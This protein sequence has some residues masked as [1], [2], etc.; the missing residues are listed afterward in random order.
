ME[1]RFS[2]I[3]QEILDAR[4][5]AAELS[6]LEVLTTSENNILTP[7]SN[8]KVAVWRVWVW[9][10]AFAIW[11]HE[12]IVNQNALNSRPHNVPWYREQV[13]AFLDGLQLVWINGQHSYDLT[14][15]NDVEARK[16]IKRT[17]V[18]E[19]NDGELV[20]KIATESGG[21]L[22]PLSAPQ[23][24][25][26]TE[27]MNL[28]KDAGNRLRI[29]NQSADLLKLTITAYVDVAIIDLETGR[30]LNV[31][32]DVYPVKDAVNEYLA[33]LD[34][35]GAFYRTFLQSTIEKATGVKLPLVTELQWKFADL[36]FQPFTEIKIPQ[37][38][39]FKIDELDLTIIYIDKNELANG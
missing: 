27:Y 30:L 34:F 9:V 21:E 18:L 31:D 13:F 11:I 8:S 39:Y 6:A 7:D 19:S 22:V 24:V 16:I 3:Q 33:N 25:R 29:I 37:A 32:G 4:N 23:L 36:D 1:R 38:G 12:K 20:I 17:A 35:N 14:N 2:E 5:D 10:I 26:F 15:I 28:I